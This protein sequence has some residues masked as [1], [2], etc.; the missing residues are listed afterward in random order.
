M[1]TM[2]VVAQSLVACSILNPQGQ[3]PAALTATP[4]ATGCIQNQRDLT[5]PWSNRFQYCKDRPTIAATERGWQE[6]PNYQQQQIRPIPIPQKNIPAPTT[7]VPVLPTDQTTTIKPSLPRNEVPNYDNQIALNEQAEQ[8]LIQPESATSIADPIETDVPK[9]SPNHT[10]ISAHS[11]PHSIDNIR[12]E[13]G[14]DHLRA[15]GFQSAVALAESI[16][17]DASGPPIIWIQAGIS[18]LEKQKLSMQQI[19]R[20]VVRRARSIREFF[21]E[22]G[23]EKDMRI[24]FRN[25]A[26]TDSVAYILK[27]EQN[28]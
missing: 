10:V 27:R 19:D 20:L 16:K 13:S 4:V 22:N 8:T 3:A 11:K 18:P 9:L 24:M 25:D 5:Q 26:V 23:V 21:A 7:I 6:V 14:A 12:F 17:R 15:S 28:I 1:A 2:V